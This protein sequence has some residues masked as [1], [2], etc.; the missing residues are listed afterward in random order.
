M[1]LRLFGGIGVFHW[2]LCC[3]V[4]VSIRVCCLSLAWFGFGL[5]VWLWRFDL[6][7]CCLRCLAWDCWFLF[8]CLWLLRAVVGTGLL[9][10]CFLGFECRVLI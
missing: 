4:V 8:V 5:A 6:F 2:Y 10:L 3:F 1:V 7:W 9:A